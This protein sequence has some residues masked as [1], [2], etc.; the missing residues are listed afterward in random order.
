MSENSIVY[1]IQRTY[2]IKP[3]ISRGNGILTCDE[4]ID[5]P[6]IE[7]LPSVQPIFYEGQ[8]LTVIPV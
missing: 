5:I 1:S 7:P 8:P 6:T 2:I 3:V 4:R